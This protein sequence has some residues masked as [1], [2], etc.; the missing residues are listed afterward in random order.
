MISLCSSANL[1]NILLHHKTQ[2]N[3][4]YTVLHWLQAVVQSFPLVFFF[5]KSIIDFVCVGDGLTHTVRWSCDCPS[6]EITAGSDTVSFKILSHPN[7]GHRLSF[8]ASA[9]YT[10]LQNATTNRVSTCWLIE[11]LTI[12]HWM[13]IIKPAGRDSDKCSAAVVMC[14]FSYSAEVNFKSIDSH[15]KFFKTPYVKS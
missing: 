15:H 10:F 5:I 1:Y 11:T 12:T 4:F 7:L 6:S 9:C 14:F 8:L 2:K 13:F 3:L